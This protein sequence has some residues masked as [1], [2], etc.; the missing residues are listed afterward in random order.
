MSAKF[1]LA[2]RTLLKGGMVAPLA[3]GP[4]ARAAALPELVL[5]DSALGIG[6][7][8]LDLAEERRRNWA[9]VRGG[10]D[11]Y[12]R[13]TGLTRWSDHVMIV[14]ELQRQGFRRA[15]IRREGR[16]WRMDMVRG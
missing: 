2:R 12:G 4:F 16:L 11:G 9:T 6:S 13:V 1:P 7:G 3:V 5:F 15:A 14:H 10:L 8:T